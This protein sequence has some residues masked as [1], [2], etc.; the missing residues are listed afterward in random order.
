MSAMFLTEP[1]QP[2]GKAEAF[3]T[4][5]AFFGPQPTL[6]L[7]ANLLLVVRPGAPFVASECS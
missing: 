1:F 7:V 5:L 2:V 6:L 4:R 3:P